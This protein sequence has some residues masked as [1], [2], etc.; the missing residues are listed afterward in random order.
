MNETKEVKKVYLREMPEDPFTE[1]T[2]SWV[3]T[4][5]TRPRMTEAGTMLMYST[6]VRDRMKR[7]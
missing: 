7:R 6:F 2:D 3:S 1:K 4:H 5:H